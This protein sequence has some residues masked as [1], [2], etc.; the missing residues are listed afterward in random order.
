[1]SLKSIQF[2]PWRMIVSLYEGVGVLPEDNDEIKLQK[3]LLVATSQTFAFFSIIWSSM[4]FYFNLKDAALIPFSYAI[5]SFISV[6]IFHRNKKVGFFRNS[7]LLMITLL[8]FILMYVLGGFFDS[9]VVFLWGLLGPVGAMLFADYRKARYWIGLYILLLFGS[10][11]RNFNLSLVYT[12]DPDTIR[13][14]ISMNVFFISLTIL[15]LIYYFVDQKARAHDL[16]TQIAHDQ[17]SGLFDNVSAVREISE[18]AVDSVLFLVINEFGLAMYSKEF[19]ETTKF[20]EQLISG[21]ITA[22]NVFSKETFG[23]NILRQISYKEFHLLFDTMYNHKFVY[24]F[25]G[26]Y[27]K[28]EFNFD[29]LFDKLKE[30]KYKSLFPSNSNVQIDP[31]ILDK[32]LV[33]IL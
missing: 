15:Y 18:E 32:L 8:P 31:E 24:A 14:F 22:I 4:Y 2:K 13:L 12:I 3:A 25:R 28:A 19:D 16:L 10:I 9:G 17:F 30:P 23:S 7:Q 21:F 26:N 6:A 27:Q 11:Y 33:E 5:L 29:N 20:N 1:M